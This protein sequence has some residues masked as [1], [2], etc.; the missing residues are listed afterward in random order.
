MLVDKQADWQPTQ[1]RVA[2]QGAFVI[3]TL[4][5]NRNHKS[6]SSYRLV[7][8][9]GTVAVSNALFPDG[10][11][12]TTLELDGLILASEATPRVA[13]DK[14]AEQ[15]AIAQAK[16]DK[17]HAKATERA[18]KATEAASKARAKAEAALATAQAK[19]AAAAASV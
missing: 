2:R 13:V 19:A 3:Q 17:A 14:A 18:N 4:V 10:V 1:Y 11:P 12:P 8:A 6:Y 16:A 5:F 9:R 7:G 15:A